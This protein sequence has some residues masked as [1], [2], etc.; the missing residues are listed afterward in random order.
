MARYLLVLYTVVYIG[1][2][3]EV[4]ELGTVQ[5]P[6]ESAWTLQCAIPFWVCGGIL[7]W[8][9]RYVVEFLVLLRYVRLEYLL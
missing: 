7:D 1:C 4:L 5:F 9:I 6:V 2:Y 3:I 8:N